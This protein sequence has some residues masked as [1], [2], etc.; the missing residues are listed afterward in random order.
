MSTFV[1]LL[2]GDLVVTDRLKR[3][4]SDA[5]VFAADSGMRHA[6]MLGV[7][8]ELW[9]GDFD[10]TS[11]DLHRQYAHIPKKTFPRAK[12]KTDGE[13]ALDEAFERG[14][15]KV[16]LCGAFGGSRVDHTLLHLTMASAQA[17]RGRNIMLTSGT[18]EAWPLVA[19]SHQFDFGQETIFSVVNFSTVEGLSITNAQWPLDNVTLPFGSSWTVSNIA[20]GTLGVTMRSGLAILVANFELAASA[21]G[22]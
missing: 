5:R 7:E 22:R 12:D 15:T 10:S 9:L 6:Q 3:Q 14:A 2:G 13:L 20:Y 16:V 1:I 21:E 19:G 8:P 17:A 4:I 11:E 18:E